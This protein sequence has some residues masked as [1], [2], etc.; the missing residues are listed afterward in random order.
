MCVCACVCVRV[1]AAGV[2][3]FVCER[4]VIRATRVDRLKRH[5]RVKG[6]G[7][8]LVSFYMAMVFFR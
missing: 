3:V 2:Y 4:S 1:F 5:R 6:C 7:I 8:I